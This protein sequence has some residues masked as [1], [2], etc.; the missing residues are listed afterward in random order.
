MHF[1]PFFIDLGAY[2]SHFSHSMPI[3][4]RLSDAG[5]KIELISHGDG[6]NLVLF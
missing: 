6:E 4:T 2:G 5:L 1:S 3:L